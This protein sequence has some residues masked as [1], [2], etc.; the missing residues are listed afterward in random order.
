MSSDFNRVTLLGT[1]L[2]N[3]E[4]RKTEAGRDMARFSMMTV[5]TWR[6]KG[7]N[8]KREKSELHHIVVF[9]D[10][11]VGLAAKHV[12]R[13][14]RVMI[15]GKLEVRPAVFPDGEVR[16][17]QEIILGVVRSSL[18]MMDSKADTQILDGMPNGPPGLPQVLLPPWV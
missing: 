14:T 8:V 5:E 3:P 9:N 11:L 12:R 1:A 18:L 15:E 4:I 10:F 16:S 13:G 2:T 17:V 7:S 6:E